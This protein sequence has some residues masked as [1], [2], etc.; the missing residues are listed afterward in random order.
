MTKY[1]QADEYFANLFEG[2][3]KILIIII[4]VFYGTLIFRFWKVQVVEG[5]IYKEFAL[6]NRIRSVIIQ[7][8]RGKIFDSEGAVLAD[9]RPGFDVEVII[10]DVPVDKK[11]QISEGLSEILNISQSTILKT[12]R[13]SRRVPYVPEKIARDINICQL[14]ELQETREKFPGINVQAIP[15]RDYKRGKFASHILGYIGKL[16]PSEYAQLKEQ[17]YNIQ[18]YI[19]RMGIEAVME[20]YLKGVHGG[21]QIQV[22]SRG[23]TDKVLG[24]KDP[25]P[26]ADVYLTIDS[27][28]QEK[29]ES[30]M[31]DR[32]GAIIV[33]DPRNGNVLAMSS[34]PSFDPN[35]FVKPTPIILLNKIFSSSKK[36]LINRAIREQYPP[37]STFK[38][39]IGISALEKGTLSNRDYYFC[40]GKFYLGSL[41]FKCWYKYG[42]GNVN[43]IDAIRYSCNVFFYNVGHRLKVKDIHKWADQFGFGKQT[44]IDLDREIPGVNPSNEWKKMNIGESWYP[45]DTIN[46]SIGQGYMLIT[47]LQLACYLCA[48]ANG[49]YL[50]KPRLIDKIVSN[51]GEVIEKKP[52]KLNNKINLSEKTYKLI[53]QGMAEVVE[54][55]YGTGSKARIKGF[56]AS[57]KTGTIQM[58]FKE[59]QVNHAWF[60]GFAPNEAP[61]IAVVIFIENAVSGGTDAAPIAGEI[62]DFYLYKRGRFIA[63][64]E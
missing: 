25:V 16:S 2:R 47:P 36:Y 53:R 44:G 57:G 3:I 58:G 8:P 27:A 13:L 35:I 43:I 19:G 1:R 34:T 23:Y 31:Q 49:G 50:Y 42:H 30:L 52:V 60:M 15:V 4:L 9:N 63:K 5:D 11:E 17:G 62:F 38:L 33:M 61:E 40:N 14:T 6:N 26:G 45:G 59:N 41:V 51:N 20:P 29:V 46:L 7:P 37:G 39:L 18:D 56:T 10:E 32:S 48:I 28:L 22:D 54:S 55:R 64:K 24:V 21:M 12:I